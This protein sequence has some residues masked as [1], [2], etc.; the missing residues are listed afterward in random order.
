MLALGMSWGMAA[1]TWPS[2]IWSVCPLIL[3]IRGILTLTCRSYGVTW[4]GILQAVAGLLGLH[5]IG[6]YLSGEEVWE[7]QK[8]R[9]WNAGVQS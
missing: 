4:R 3:G 9:S 7:P 2:R 5:T 8:L 1:G 6:G